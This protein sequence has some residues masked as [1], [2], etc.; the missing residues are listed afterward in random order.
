MERYRQRCCCLSVLSMLAIVSAFIRPD[1]SHLYQAAMAMHCVCLA[2]KLSH[3][4]K[5]T[6]EQEAIMNLGQSRSYGGTQTSLDGG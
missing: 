1:W 4:S 3:A 6:N 5:R 2:T